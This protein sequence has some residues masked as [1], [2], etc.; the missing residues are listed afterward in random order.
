MAGKLPPGGGRAFRALGLVL[1]L[2]RRQQRVG[3]RLDAEGARV[4]GERVDQ[5]GLAGQ[6]VEIVD[7]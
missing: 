1:V 5:R 3:G 7:A 6:G 4:A 2:T